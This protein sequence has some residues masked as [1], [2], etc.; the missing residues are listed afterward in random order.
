MRNQPLSMYEN[1]QADNLY[2]SAQ[3]Q[4]ESEINMLTLGKAII[5]NKEFEQ[6]VEDTQEYGFWMVKNHTVL[7]DY[8]KLEN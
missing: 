6:L 3:N 4:Y 1:I 8:Y 7:P 2:Y 5:L